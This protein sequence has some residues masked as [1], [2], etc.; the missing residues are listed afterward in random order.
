MPRAT[1][2]READERGAPIAFLAI[3]L[4][5]IWILAALVFIFYIRG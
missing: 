5:T 2:F 3:A 1:D 4:V